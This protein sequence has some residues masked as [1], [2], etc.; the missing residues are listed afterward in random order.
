MYTYGDA[1]K[2]FFAIVLFGMAF[3]IQAQDC[4]AL[5]IDP[6]QTSVSGVS[7]GAYMAGQLAVAHSATFMGLGLIAGGPYYCA[8]SSLL[9]AMTFCMDYLHSKIDVS[10]L[11]TSAKNFETSKIIDSLA[12]FKRMRIYA[13][14][15]SNDR[16][17]PQDLVASNFDFFKSLGVSP[18]QFKFD[19]DTA[20]GHAFPTLDY[21]NECSAPRE[22]PFISK[23]G[24]DGAL[25]I[26]TQ[27]YGSLKAKTTA[28]DEN[29]FEVTQAT[30]SM[31]IP[32]AFSLADYATLYVPTQ[33]QVGGKCKLH[34]ALHG[35]RQTK[36]DIGDQFI[37]HTGYAEWAETNDIIVLFPQ[38]IRNDDLGNPRGCWDWWGYSSSFYATKEGPQ[39][40]M[41]YELVQS[42]GQGKSLIL[43][44][45]KN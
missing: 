16:V 44:H 40:K 43:S 34:V 1:M 5:N 12:N 23:C 4:Q 25:Q 8:Q 45:F 14:S 17:V 27:I 36:E 31:P 6:K 38:A 13:F 33:C 26:L 2:R 37:K 28:K 20:A 19:S 41:I 29:F 11:V 18:D 10:E 22:A 42:I 21:G 3:W 9:R 35:C 15:G 30:S 32:K 7:S 24:V 39:I